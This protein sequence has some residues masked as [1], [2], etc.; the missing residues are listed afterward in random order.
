MPGK[1][2]GYDG[3]NRTFF[4]AAFEP[5][6]YYDSTPFNL[7]VPTDAMRRGD[8]SNAVTVT[9]GVTTRDV[10][11]RFGLQSQPLTIYN[12]YELVGNQLR[13]VTLPAGASFPE[14]PNNVIPG[15]MLDP[16][17]QE[18]MKYLPAP[19]DYFLDTDGALRNYADEN[20][21][22][23]S[24]AA[25]H[26]ARRS[27]PDKRQPPH[28]PVHAGPD[29]RRSRAQRVR[30]GPRRGQHRRHGLQLVAPVPRDRHPH[31]LVVRGQRSAVQLHLRPVHAKLSA[32]IRRVHGAEPLDRARVAEPDPGR[33]A[34]VHHRGRQYRLEPVA[35]ERKRGA[36][37]HAG[38][39]GLG[40]AWAAD[41]EV[42]RRFPAAAAEDDSDVRRLRRPLRVQPQHDA[43][44]QRVDERD[45]RH[46][47]RPVP[48][49][50]LQPDHAS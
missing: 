50:H 43:H 5:R 16:M 49:R 28:R 47:V 22:T 6:Y 38:R 10:A 7:L 39:H 26:G 41:L 12:Q 1:L 32:W 33:A 14:F 48:A 21:I 2:G 4:F 8:F 17:A 40:G 36:H 34:G 31:P 23:K 37:V 46:P 24:R 9:G 18:L 42:R 27:Q 3:R 35:A 44:Q 30:S 45:R 15:A 25:L 20:F 11:Q 13:R 29:P 19:G